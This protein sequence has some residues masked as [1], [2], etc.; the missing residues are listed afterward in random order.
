[1]KAIDITPKI[2]ESMSKQVLWSIDLFYS[3]SEQLSINGFEV[4][5]WDG[6]ENWAGIIFEDTR[7]GFLWKKYPLFFI[8]ES[9]SDKIKD[10]LRQYD[11]LVYVIVDD[12]LKQQFKLNNEELNYYFSQGGIN[13]HRFSPENLWFYTN[14]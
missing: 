2:K 8:L 1:M 10:C 14:F 12:L 4:S 6:E 7:V 5:F 13:F 9:I 11:F 3:V